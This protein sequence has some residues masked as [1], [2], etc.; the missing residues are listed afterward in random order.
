MKSTIIGNIS[1]IFILAAAIIGISHTAMS[2]PAESYASAS[3]LSSGRWVKI[4]VDR[5]GVYGLSRATLKSMGFSDP[6]RV[7]I[8][9][10]GAAPKT[11]RLTLAGYR[12]DLPMVQSVVRG[13]GTLVFYGQ[14]ASTWR[15]STSRRYT[16]SNSLYATCGTYFVTEVAD[17]V[18]ARPINTTGRAGIHQSTVYDSFLDR[19]HHEQDLVSPGESGAQLMGEDFRFTPSRTF[20]FDL[21]DRTDDNTVWMELS[22]VAKTFTQSST[23]AISVNGTQLESNSGDRIS[24]TTNDSHYHGQEGLSRRSFQATGNRLSITVRHNSPVTVERAWLNYITINYRRQ[25]RLGSDGYLQFWFSDYMAGAMRLAGV[26][27]AGVNIWNVTDPSD[28]KIVNTG[29]VTDGTVAW[30][31]ERATSD[32]YV[33]WTENARLPEPRILGQVA[34]QN[35]HSHQG[36]DMV[37]ITLPA[38]KAQAERLAAIHRDEKPTGMSVQVVETDQIYNEFGSGTADPWAIRGYLKMIYDRAAAQGGKLRY[39]LLMGRT[40]YDSRRLSEAFRTIDISTIP[41]WYSPMMSHSLS[42][43]YGYP[44]DDFYAMLEDNSCFDMSFDD[45]DISVGRMPV[46]SVREATVAVDKIVRYLESLPY[47]DWRQKVLVVADDQDNGVHMDQAESFQAA[48]NPDDDPSYVLDKIYLDAYELANGKYARARDEMFKDLNDGTMLW[49]YLGHASTTS[50]SHEHQLTYQDINSKLYYKTLPMVFAGTCDF[51]RWDENAECGAETM[52]HLTN[53]GVIAMISA[54]RPVYI[55]ENGKYAAALG[56][57]FNRTTHRG[58]DLRAGDYYRLA[59]NDIRNKDGEHE[60][61]ANRLR[62]AFMGDPALKLAMPDN[63]VNLR[64]IGGIDVDDDSPAD[65]APQAIVEALQ[66]ATFTGDITDA[67]G[68][69]LDDFNGTL[70]LNIYDAMF[71]TTSNGYGKDGKQ[72]TYDR[73]GSKL[74]SGVTTVENGRWQAKVHM[75]MEVAHNFRP[76]LAALYAHDPTGGAQASGVNNR[77]YVYGNHTP[78]V[79][80]TIPPVIES[81]VLNHTTFTDGA[82]VNLSPTVLAKVS[83][84]IGINISTAGIGHQLTLTLD[85]KTTISD[86]ASYFKPATDGSASGTISYPLAALTPGAHTLRLR[87]WDT[88]GNSSSQTISFHAAAEAA[89]TI[90]DVWTDANPATASANFYISHDRPDQTA[91]VTITVYNLL[92]APVWSDSV[93]G[94]ADMFTS[95]PVVWDLT[96]SAGRRVDRGIYLYRA[97]ITTDSEQFDTASKKIAVAAQ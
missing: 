6:A 63:L 18:P 77:F 85:D 62:Y 75:P 44:G 28:I 59:K 83:D 68:N 73:H 39:A 26:P 34:N 66:T 74:Y 9:G 81:F 11:D 80:D 37:I 43:N 97:T 88:S 52:Y 47:G 29:D 42:D 94:P 51:M 53:G 95:A 45:L 21:T 41:S 76:A 70:M 40:T 67:A 50:W 55:S 89:P 12:D 86:A 92:G 93:T 33:A 46:R 7:R 84:N 1:R 69:V 31:P 65:D 27:A 15:E 32:A 5:D 36:V 19:L 30:T 8:Y 4:A 61:N 23:L 72:V 54:T 87:V 91:T 35:L 14:S 16:A 78:E 22:F 60:S 10:Y 82:L 13:D 56:R 71:S 49:I 20:N 25:L 2:F 79:P 58:I 3:V 38:F 48:S 17:T 96:D 57:A 24:P 90:Y 64:T